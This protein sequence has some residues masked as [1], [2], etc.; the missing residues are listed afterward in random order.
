VIEA[1]ALVV[2]GA[3]VVVKGALEELEAV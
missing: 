3:M 1:G 2:E